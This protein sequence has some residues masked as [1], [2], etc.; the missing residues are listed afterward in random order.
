[1]GTATANRRAVLIHGMDQGKGGCA[2]YYGIRTQLDPANR[3]KSPT[4]D[5][6]ILRSDSKC[7]RDMSPLFSFMPR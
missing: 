1:M 7:R 3:L 4:R 6:N 5:V 2:E